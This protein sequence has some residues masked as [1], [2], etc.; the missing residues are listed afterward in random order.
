[1]TTRQE[2]IGFILKHAESPQ[3]HGPMPDPSITVKG[4]GGECGESITLYFRV[5]ETRVVDASFEAEGTTIGRAAASL[6]TETVIGKTLQEVLEI[7]P[8]EIV[9][10]LGRDI[11]GDRLRSA[12]VTLDTAK[13]AARRYLGL[14]RQGPR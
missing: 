1:M 13:T 7:S 6:T 9:N 11:V 4:G 3:H 12:T 8:D 14:E 5:D 2:R 10:T